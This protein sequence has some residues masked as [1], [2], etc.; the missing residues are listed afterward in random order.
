MAAIEGCMGTAR[1]WAS[2]LGKAA[3]DDEEGFEAAVCK[4]REA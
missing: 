3:E 2:Q 4:R 1:E